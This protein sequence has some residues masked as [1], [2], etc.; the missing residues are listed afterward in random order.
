LLVTNLAEQ[1][2]VL[3]K[4]QAQALDKTL[5]LMAATGTLINVFARLAPA[6]LAAASAQNIM[7]AATA[8]ADALAG[9]LGWA[10]LAGAVAALA[11]WGLSQAIP[12]MTGQSSSQSQPAAV[13]PPGVFSGSGPGTSPSG[14]AQTSL[15]F[16]PVGTHGGGLIA[17]IT[18]QGITDPQQVATQVKSYLESLVAR[19]MARRG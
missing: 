4:K 7:N 3:D 15:P 18:I 5:S 10:L 1:F 14:G 9:P 11:A 13:G 19:E 6:V 17:P 12:G 16:N 8:V 2:G